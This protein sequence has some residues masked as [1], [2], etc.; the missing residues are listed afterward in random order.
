MKTIFKILLVIVLLTLSAQYTKAGDTL[1]TCWTMVFPHDP[2]HGY[3]NPDSVL[4]DTCLCKT[5]P[6]LPPYCKYVYAKQWFGLDLPKGALNIP[7]APRDSIILRNWRD[8]DSSFTELRDGLQNIEDM[9]SSFIMRK[10]FPDYGD[11]SNIF[12]LK[13]NYYF[14][15]DSVVYYLKQIY[16]LVD[17]FYDYR[18]SVLASNYLSEPGFELGNLKEDGIKSR[19]VNGCMDYHKNSLEWNLF[20]IHVPMAWEI[21]KGKF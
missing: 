9:F 13:F 3:Y 15:I 10:E 6:W 17:A 20:S 2:D 18:Y 4:Y 5:K 1:D 12:L 19:L 14:N 21:T 7:K 16:T 8:I 11:S